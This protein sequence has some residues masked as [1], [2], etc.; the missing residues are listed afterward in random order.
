METKR[1]SGYKG[2]WACADDYPD[3]EVPVEN[4]NR[5]GD[6]H[7]A[8]C[9]KCK[10]VE[11]AYS[12]PRSN[13]RNNPRSNAISKI[14]YGIAGSAGEFYKLDKSERKII[15]ATATE[16]YKKEKPALTLVRNNPPKPAA[17][18]M[19]KRVGGTMEGEVVP[20]GWV[21]MI[22]NPEVPHLLK[23]GRTYP[24]GLNSRLS[25]AQRWGRAELVGQFWF[26]DASEAETSIHRMLQKWNL[27]N[28]GYIDCGKELFHVSTSM[29]RKVV[30]EYR[31]ELES[32]EDAIG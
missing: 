24:D 16:R 23:I 2:V 26:E 30:D 21:Y 22:G 29:A 13:P 32:I 6:G 25:E 28:M 20:E 4:F 12:S 8:I 15:R 3:H 9:R 1:C 11:K 19:R 17:Q 7:Q 14:A 5:N 27:R 31:K 10:R 18:P